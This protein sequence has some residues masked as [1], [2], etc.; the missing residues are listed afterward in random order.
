[1]SPSPSQRAFRWGEWCSTHAPNNVY[2]RLSGFEHH[3]GALT[4]VE[5]F[6]REA[7]DMVCSGCHTEIRN[8]NGECEPIYQKEAAI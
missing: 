7:D 3:C 2:L 8:P 4:S 5:N 6:E 1:M